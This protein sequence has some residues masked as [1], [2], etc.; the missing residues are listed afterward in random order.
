MYL[1]VPTSMHN[2][3]LFLSEIK[4]EKC[5]L[6]YNWITSIIDYLMKNISMK[7]FNGVKESL[8]IVNEYLIVK[9]GIFT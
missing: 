4:R 3:A 8:N 9:S 5:Y 1:L 6:N 2:F 7:N